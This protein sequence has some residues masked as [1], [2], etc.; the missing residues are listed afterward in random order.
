MDEFY[1]FLFLKEPGLRNVVLGTA[2]LSVCT[3]LIGTFTI[4]RKRALS[5]DVISHAILPGICLAF[6]FSGEK[7]IVYLMIGAFTSGWL[8][9]L[10]VDKIVQYSKIKEDTA[11]AIILSSFYGLGV[12]LLKIIDKLPNYPDKAG[13]NNYLFGSATQIIQKDLINFG[14]VSIIIFIVLL[15]YYRYFKILSFDPIFAKSTGLNVPYLE[16]LLTSLTVLAV[17]IGIQTVGVVLMAAML[18]TPGAVALF[19]TKKLHFTLLLSTLLGIV[20][21]WLGCFT[22]YFL[23]FKTALGQEATPT[24]P[25]IVMFLSMFGVLSFFFTPKKGILSKYIKKVKFKKQIQMENILK[26]LY[27]N[28]DTK[29]ESL[30]F[31]EIK[32]VSP[33]PKKDLKK[34]LALLT[35]AG[36]LTEKKGN[37]CLTE[38]GLNKGKRITK[39]HRLWELY[40]TNYMNIDA[41]NVHDEAESIEHILTPELEKSLEQQL[42]FPKKD[43]HDKP[44]PY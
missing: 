21:S 44:I 31:N 18:I 28:F 25:A 10:L 20:S 8:S 17:I 41:K 24:G 11:L 26:S 5:G 23:T 35:S 22:S 36:Y 16:F 38:I 42:N 34:S 7:N 33:L 1:N 43:P 2:L 32:S 4:L 9:L 30:C 19:W 13:L 37:F 39:I 12:V 40:L 15:I 29:E 14:V 6:I 27:K 3:S